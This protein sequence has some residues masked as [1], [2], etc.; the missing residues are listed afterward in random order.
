MLILPPT[1]AIFDVGGPEVLMILLVA[2]LL[3]GSQRL[4]ELA[5]NLG[6]S[7][8]EFK[9]ATSGLE[10]ELKRAIEAPPPPPRPRPPANPSFEQAP[11]ISATESAA[12]SPSQE[13]EKPPG[14]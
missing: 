5:R 11:G 9:K 7:I 1:L 12:A 8:R 13:P 10:E 6:K 14:P 3:F 4:P 2:L